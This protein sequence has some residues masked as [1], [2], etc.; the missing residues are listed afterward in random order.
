LLLLPALNRG[1]YQIFVG[2]V[3]PFILPR[4]FAPLIQ[5]LFD[6]GFV[7]AIF[8]R[9]RTG[10]PVRFCLGQARVS[11]RTLPDPDVVCYWRLRSF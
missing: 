1:N 4:E 9:R 5:K 6:F 11:S 10:D 3:A 2:A 8:G 7:F